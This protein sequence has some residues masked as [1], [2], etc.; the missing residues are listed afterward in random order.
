MKD[1]TALEEEVTQSYERSTK[2]A[3]GEIERQH[4]V[5]GLRQR[6]RDEDEEQTKDCRT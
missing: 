1:K 5:F 2:A 4:S 6:S 3:E